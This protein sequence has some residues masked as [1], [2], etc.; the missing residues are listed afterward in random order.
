MSGGF[1]HLLGMGALP[2]LLL[3]IPSGCGYPLGKVCLFVTLDRERRITLVVVPY[4]CC[5]PFLG[6]SSHIPTPS[7]GSSELLVAGGC[8]LVWLVVFDI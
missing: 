8:A 6:S 7:F 4:R 5:H 3:C 2:P 1:P